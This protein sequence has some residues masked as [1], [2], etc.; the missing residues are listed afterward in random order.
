MKNTNKKG[1]TIVELVIV[2][3]VIAILAAV[4]IPTFVGL[5]NKANLSADQQAVRQMN[6]AIAMTGK[7]ITDINT[8]ID[9]LDE[10]GYNSKKTL[11]PV[12]KGH[13]FYWD[14][15]TNKIILVDAN[16]AV[17][18]PADATYVAGDEKYHSL[19]AS[20]VYVDIDA[21]DSDSLVDAVN[22]GHKDITLT[23]DLTVTSAVYSAKGTDIVIDLN[24]KTL[25]TGMSDATKHCYAF[26]VH[27]T[28]TLTN[29]TI[30]ARGIKIHDGGKL[31]LGEGA[32]VNHVDDNGGAC[33]WVYEGAEVVVDGGEFIAEKGKN[34]VTTDPAVISNFGGKITI[35]GGKFETTVSYAYA[36]NNFSG[37]LIIKD[38][39]FSGYRGVIAA[40]GGTV[41]IDGGKFTVTGD[42]SADS[43]VAHTVYADNG[44]VVINGGEFVSGM[45]TFCVDSEGTGKIT[46]AAGVVVDGDATTEA[47]TITK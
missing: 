9:T 16:N 5:V 8:L 24:G 15:T 25:T 35:N 13:T 22:G 7:E 37:E 23:T 29:G 14:S 20:I 39:E 33:L 3:A 46:V 42:Y 19:E 26:D 4:L 36:I 47:Q 43:N 10:Q 17:V 45:T 6:Q 44:T 21:N 40:A 2:I 28:V 30:D 38:G 32:K 34:T 31:V 12:S 27:G 18:F 41:T 1:F 11:V